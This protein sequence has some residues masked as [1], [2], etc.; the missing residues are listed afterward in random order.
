MKLAD[1]I[2]WLPSESERSAPDAFLPL[3]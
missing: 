2:V 3:K 1:E